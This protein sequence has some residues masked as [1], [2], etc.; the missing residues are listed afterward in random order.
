VFAV[1]ERRFVEIHS[2]LRADFGLRIGLEGVDLNLYDREELVRYG[3]RQ[4]TR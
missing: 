1:P 4:Y 3:R 2:F